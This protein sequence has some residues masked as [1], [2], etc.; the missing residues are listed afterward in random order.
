MRG[1]VNATVPLV[2]AVWRRVF[3]ICAAMLLLLP[4]QAGAQNVV[5]DWSRI[6]RTCKS[7]N[8]F[9]QKYPDADANPFAKDARDLRSELQ[10]RETVAKPRK[11]TRKDVRLTDNR[12]TGSEQG[13]K[14][15]DKPGNSPKP[16][17]ERKGPRDSQKADAAGRTRAKPK[18]EPTVQYLPVATNAQLAREAFARKDYRAALDR[19][20][21]SCNKDANALSCGQAAWLLVDAE[22]YALGNA[23]YPVAR[24]Y[25]ERNCDLLRE[26]ASCD[27]ARVV[28]SWQEYGGGKVDPGRAYAYFLRSGKAIGKLDCAGEYATTCEVLGRGFLQAGRDYATTT[29]IFAMA[30]NGGDARGCLQA[31]IYTS[32]GLGRAPGIQ[33]HLRSEALLRMG[34]DKKLAEACDKAMVLRATTLYGIVEPALARRYFSTSSKNVGTVDCRTPANDVCYNLGLAYSLPQYGQVVQYTADILFGRAC[35]ADHAVS[36]RLVG[37]KLLNARNHAAAA[38]KFVKGC[39]GNDGESCFSASK[40]YAWSAFSGNNRYL[41]LQY[42][43]RACTLKI[44]AA[45]TMRY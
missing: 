26:E 13:A 23:N 6:E 4:V 17:E 12:P 42:A 18:R 14:T 5:D 34:C 44:V 9:L 15:K 16:R 19:F 1:A 21:D 40:L 32:Q 7:V 45:C 30:C 27:N 36:C 28:N 35:E 2:E 25:F 8:R 33:D 39:N 11:D 29:S 20:S 38:E 10:C 3:A 24:T 31:G 22:K 43:R 37:I 41:A